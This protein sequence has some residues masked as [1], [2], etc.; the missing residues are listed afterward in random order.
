MSLYKQL[1]P[2]FRSLEYFFK[3]FR[4]YLNPEAYLSYLRFK[5]AGLNT[6]NDSQPC[7]IFDFKNVEIDYVGGRY[8]YYL[9][10][11]AIAAGYHP[12]YINNFRFL[13]TLP[14]KQFKK[15]LLEDPFGVVPR[16][17]HFPEGSLYFYDHAAPS[18]RVGKRIKVSYEPHIAT[19]PEE[20]QLPFAFFPT[21]LKKEKELLEL[22]ENKD[23]KKEIFF[24]GKAAASSHDKPALKVKYNILTRVSAIR[25]IEEAAERGILPAD[26]LHL[27]YQPENRIPPADW[28]KTMS[29][30]AFFLALPGVGMPMCHNLVEA[31]AMG[32]IPILQYA[33][34]LDPPLQDGKECLT[35]H[36]DVSLIETI[37]KALQMPLEEREALSRGAINYYLK[38]LKL[39]TFTEKL[40]SAPEEIL[41]LYVNGNRTPRV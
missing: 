24:G 16:K 35:F 25:V 19:A 8:L 20:F 11:D 10:Q 23:I 29:E 33:E 22:N 32:S 3:E 30:S 4:A 9:V 31:L 28:M 27:H 36:D 5:K 1:R 39:G 14:Y 38:H 15:L 21:L 40:I 6:P 13:A 18:A 26:Q 12:V 34:Y 37:H 7:A 41:T 17:T 2:A